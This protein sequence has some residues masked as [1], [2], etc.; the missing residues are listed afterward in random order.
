MH[1]LTTGNI[2]RGKKLLKKNV[3]RERMALWL[4]YVVYFKHDNL[5]KVDEDMLR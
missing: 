2:W 3:G 1:F 5:V 4:G